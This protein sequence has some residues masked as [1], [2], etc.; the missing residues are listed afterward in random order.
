MA[1][2][3]SENTTLDCTVGLHCLLF[4]HAT[5]HPN[6]YDDSHTDTMTPAQPLGESLIDNDHYDSGSI[7]AG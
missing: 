3:C 4:T 2:C 5:S 6:I 7:E 1:P